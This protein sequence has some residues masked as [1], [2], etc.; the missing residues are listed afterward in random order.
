M[1][2][3]YRSYTQ[4]RAEAPRDLDL[5]CERTPQ[6]L[7][8]AMNQELPNRGRI[9]ANGYEDRIK[10]VKRVYGVTHKAQMTL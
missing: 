8:Y 5:H 1:S 2:I 4:A 6:L 9:L 7:Q 3:G 10:E